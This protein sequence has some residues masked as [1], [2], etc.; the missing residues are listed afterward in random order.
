MQL[1]YSFSFLC[2]LYLKNIQ[3][4][5]NKTDFVKRDFIDDNS[6]EEKYL[7][8][9][10]LK[11]DDN[12]DEFHYD[13]EKP[14]ETKGRHNPQQLRN[15]MQRIHN[16]WFFSSPYL[17]RRGYLLRKNAALKNKQKRVLRDSN[18]SRLKSRQTIFSHNVMPIA[19]DKVLSPLFVPPPDINT[20]MRNPIMYQPPAPSTVV[21]L[22]HFSLFN[23]VFNVPLLTTPEIGSV[24]EI[25][26]TIYYNKSP[27]YNITV[28]SIATDNA[29]QDTSKSNFNR[30]DGIVIYVNTSNELSIKPIFCSTNNVLTTRPN[31]SDP[32]NW[33]INRTI[34]CPS[35]TT[36]QPAILTLLITQ[37]IKE[38]DLNQFNSLPPSPEVTT[39]PYIPWSYNDLPTYAPITESS[40][41]NPVTK[42]VGIAPLAVANINVTIAA[43]IEAPNSVLVVNQETKSNAQ[44]NDSC[45]NI[46]SE[47]ERLISESDDL[48]ETT[49][50]DNCTK[51]PTVAV[52]I[53]AT[54]I[55]PGEVHAGI[56]LTVGPIQI[57]LDN[58][59]VCQPATTMDAE[60]MSKMS[61]LLQFKAHLHHDVYDIGRKPHKPVN[62]TAIQVM[63]DDAKRDDIMF[64]DLEDDTT[65]SNDITTDIMD[66]IIKMR[67][68][69][70]GDFSSASS[71]PD[72]SDTARQQDL[73]AL[74]KF[75]EA[76]GIT[77]E[78][79]YNYNYNYNPKQ[80]NQSSTNQQQYEFRNLSDEQARKNIQKRNNPMTTKLH[81]GVKSKV[82]YDEIIKKRLERIFDTIAKGIVRNTTS[83]ENVYDGSD[84]FSEYGPGDVDVGDQNVEEIEMARLFN[85]STT[86]NFKQIWIESFTETNY[87]TSVLEFSKKP[88]TKAVP[89]TPATEMQSILP[90]IPAVSEVSSFITSTNTSLINGNL[91]I[92]L[93]IPNFGNLDPAIFNNNSIHWAAAVADR[94]YNNFTNKNLTVNPNLVNSI[95]NLKSEMDKSNK[96]LARVASVVTSIPTVQD[97]AIDL[98]SNRMEN[99]LLKRNDGAGV[100]PQKLTL[101]SQLYAENSASDIT[102]KNIQSVMNNIPYPF[103]KPE[104]PNEFK[105][106]YTTSNLP[107]LSLINANLRKKRRF[108]T[109]QP[110]LE[111]Q[112]NVVNYFFD[113]REIN[114]NNDISQ[115]SQNN[116]IDSQYHTAK[117]E[118]AT[119]PYVET[120]RNQVFRNNSDNNNFQSENTTYFEN[121]HDSISPT[122]NGTTLETCL[123]LCFCLNSTVNK[124]PKDLISSS[125][126][127]STSNYVN[128]TEP[129]AI[130]YKNASDNIGNV[131]K[132]TTFNITTPFSGTGTENKLCKSTTEHALSQS[133]QLSSK[134]PSSTSLTNEMTN[135]QATINNTINTNMNYTAHNKSATNHSSLEKTTP[136]DLF[137]STLKNISTAQKTTVNINNTML[138]QTTSSITI[139]DM[140][141][142]NNKEITSSNVIVPIYVDNSTESFSVSP[143]NNSVKTENDFL[144]KILRSYAKNNI[145]LH[146]DTFTNNLMNKINGLVSNNSASKSTLNYAK[147][148]SPNTNT[149]A[150]EKKLKNNA[151]STEY[152]T[153]KK[154]NVNRTS[155]VKNAEMTK[156]KNTPGSILGASYSNH[157]YTTNLN[158]S[159]L[160]QSKLYAP[161][162]IFANNINTKTKEANN[163]YEKN[164]YSSENQIHFSKYPE[165][166]ILN[167]NI[168]KNKATPTPKNVAS[169][170][171]QYQINI[172]KFLTTNVT[173]NYFATDNTAF[174]YITSPLTVMS[175]DN[176]QMPVL[177]IDIN[178]GNEA[179]NSMYSSTNHA[180][181]FTN[182]S[183]TT[184]MTGLK[185]LVKKSKIV[186]IEPQQTEQLIEAQNF[187]NSKNDNYHAQSQIIPDRPE[188]VLEK[189]KLRC[190]DDKY[191]M[192]LTENSQIE[193]TTSN[194]GVID[195][196]D[197]VELST[198]SPTIRFAHMTELAEP[199][200]ETDEEDLE[201]STATPKGKIIMEKLLNM[202]IE[203][204]MLKNIMENTS[205]Q[206]APNKKSQSKQ[207]ITTLQGT[208]STTFTSTN[209]KN[210]IHYDNKSNKVS[211]E[212]CF[213]KVNSSLINTTKRNRTV[214]HKTPSYKIN[215]SST[216]LHKMHNFESDANHVNSTEQY[217]INDLGFPIKNISTSK[218]YASSKMADILKNYLFR[219]KKPP[220][221]Q[222]NTT[223]PNKEINL[224]TN[225]FLS[226]KGNSTISNND[227]RTSPTIT[228]SNFTL[229]PRDVS[230]KE[231]M[232]KDT[233]KINIKK[234]STK[235]F[236]NMTERHKTRTVNRIKSLLAQII[237]LIKHKTSH[238]LKLHGN[239]TPTE[240]NYNI[241]SNTNNITLLSSNSVTK[242]PITLNDNKNSATL[243]NTK[244]IWPVLANDTT[245]IRGT[246]ANTTNDI[247]LDYAAISA[248]LSKN[249]TALD[250]DNKI[251]SSSR[252]SQIPNAKI[253]N[254]DII[255]EL[256]TES[257][258]FVLFK[259]T[260]LLPISIYTT[261]N[262]FKLLNI[263]EL[264]PDKRN[265][266]QKVY[267][268]LPTFYP[269][270]A[271]H[272]PDD[273][274]E[275]SENSLSLGFGK[276]EMVDYKNL[277]M[278]DMF[279]T[280]NSNEINNEDILSK[281]F[282]DFD[283]YFNRFPDNPIISPIKYVLDE[284]FNKTHNLCADYINNSRCVCSVDSIVLHFK[285]F[286]SEQNSTEFL[287]SLSSFKC[288]LY[289]KISTEFTITKELSTLR[290]R[291][292][293]KRYNFGLINK[294]KRSADYPGYYYPETTTNIIDT[295]ELGDYYTVPGSNVQ[296]S[297]MPAQDMVI[298]QN[299]NVKY[300]WL[301]DDLPITG[302]RIVDNFGLLSIS[303]IVA[304]DGGRYTCTISLKPDPENYPV[305]GGLNKIFAYEVNVVEI[306]LYT[307]VLQI[308]YNMSTKCDS[309]DI[310][311]ISSYLPDIVR[312]V[313]CGKQSR[314][315]SVDV[316]KAQCDL[317][318]VLT[319]I[320]VQ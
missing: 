119:T 83:H 310:D 45:Y 112:N 230:G 64:R 151:C 208:T 309:Q 282:T 75:M 38:S 255:T 58:V 281:S 148:I 154:L 186:P 66:A 84:V 305:T 191:I 237:P 61:R 202:S 256:T 77:P 67:N 22:A 307:F 253:N 99:N 4:I 82:T 129:N 168:I 136:H 127:C 212:N 200:N 244:T 277:L 180:N 228:L 171:N 116:Y 6:G 284:Q 225:H 68:V 278:D 131:A 231:N 304:S 157:L 239:V 261:V 289:E 296:L 85:L 108:A 188:T 80:I 143:I 233:S 78:Y 106:Q 56:Q 265:K 288:D 46:P 193:M 26:N 192:N 41:F 220:D 52:Q 155:L 295:I 90:D 59:T 313:A 120:K 216:P 2:T 242:A 81:R 18:Q 163:M 316:N 211:G 209:N 53:N 128:S 132:T 275:N 187:N 249:N 223:Q 89:I 105:F 170:F 8:F 10:P 15:L 142:N 44:Y 226:Y 235:T 177:R 50:S 254:T 215:S 267:L 319:L 137:L 109:N 13:N 173:S 152:N 311:V 93:I 141:N 144:K 55:M 260:H 205:E 21:D 285:S 43:A 63:I 76:H 269:P 179:G 227:N 189:Y 270:G 23:Q 158:S 167:K 250:N 92:R 247:D 257:T 287:Q 203:A 214:S 219:V 264:A 139:H 94:S 49:T 97:G 130:I 182:S 279:S 71:I 263:S 248:I 133:Q 57:N 273:D 160:K 29:K 314:I 213:H 291:T 32:R 162:S 87:N 181:V 297:C 100:L 185:Q 114:S 88:T 110:F 115:Q 317:S 312:S 241:T 268:H 149:S 79:N 190:D 24:T 298:M 320:I 107:I 31:V 122:N 19:Q 276:H 300:V 9:L 252:V 196:D 28:R 113:R 156:P 283:L 3:G 286:L 7:F 1:S 12:K 199:D 27:D 174:K 232:K 42:D 266:T 198:S 150:I 243:M 30:R 14:F 172:Q 262:I 229:K 91:K 40:S 70:L 126:S 72:Y 123:T 175:T 37:F 96:M 218:N 302:S 290:G 39:M 195:T 124:L 210:S 274:E 146:N 121:N 118:T 104:N 206:N 5:C 207:K 318:K 308:S 74:N 95:L 197:Y 69:K 62:L 201:L 11:I 246:E 159:E 251:D 234:N 65:C 204:N 224:T 145:F 48:I 183:S 117:L 101:L 240:F 147:G 178:P 259:V 176:F 33:I 164:I 102:T 111:N 135:F 161:T 217:L 292:K 303:N 153:T 294:V 221:N 17:K 54:V 166:T 125:I 34:S 73:E 299:E 301:K 165:N 222:K 280:E 271:K 35:D 86:E 36:T 98:S 47:S 60:Q 25:G 315:C 134:N 272:F 293:T 238:N 16:N 194:T 140:D 138:K 245:S 236:N 103:V 258:P 20:I 169:S 51:A 306:P 184:K